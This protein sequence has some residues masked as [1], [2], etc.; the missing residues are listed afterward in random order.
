[1][2]LKEFARVKALVS[3]YKLALIRWYADTN[4]HIAVLLAEFGS[5]HCGCGFGLL[6]LLFI[7]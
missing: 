7:L 1:V 2:K 4:Y 3:F 5:C 6:L